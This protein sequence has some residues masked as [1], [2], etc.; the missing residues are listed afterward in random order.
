LDASNTIISQC[1]WELSKADTSYTCITGIAI[2]LAIPSPGLINPI[3][4][5]T[6]TSTETCTATQTVLVTSTSTGT[7]IPQSP[8]PTPSLVAFTSSKTL[9]ISEIFPAPSDKKDWDGDG[10]ASAE[11]EWI[12]L[13]N[14]GEDTIH[15]KSWMLDD[16]EG[17]SKPYVFPEESS[18]SAN[19]CLV[20]SRKQTG[21]V[22]NN[23]TDTVRLYSG[24]VLVDSYTYEGIKSDQS[25]QWNANAWS[26]SSNPN[27]LTCSLQEANSSEFPPSFASTGIDLFDLIW[28]L[29]VAFGAIFWYSKC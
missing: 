4:T 16:A 24:T 5:V 7:P 6:A 23:T 21:I 17:G 10:V 15:L 2:E 26:V 27:P 9:R 12:E 22:L 13:R 20:F 8:T 14:Y 1:S 29:L 3:P 11:D 28:E 18:I 19:G 25:V